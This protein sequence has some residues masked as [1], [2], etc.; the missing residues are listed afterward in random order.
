MAIDFS[1]VYSQNFDSLAISGA[2]LAWSNNV[3]L[4]GW[5][6]FNKNLS[7]IATY[8]A[9]DGNTNVGNFYS[10]GVSGAAER[11]LGGIASGNVYFG[12][13]VPLANDVAGWV[14]VAAKNVTGSTLD[15]LTLSFD[16]EQWR[17][18]GNMTAQSMVLQYG[19]GASFSTVSSWTT[20]GGNFDWTSPVA[21]TP[22]AP[23]N[24]NVEG[25]VAN[26]G[27]TLTGLNWVSNETLWIRWVELNNAGSDHGLA[28]DNFRMAIPEVIITESGS[29]TQVTE[30]GA[31]DSYTVVLRTPPSTGTLVTVALN[32]G[33]QVTVDQPTLVFTDLTWNV[34]KTVTVMA[35]DDAAIEGNHTGMIAHTVTSGDAAYNGLSVAPLTVSITDNDS[36]P[37]VAPVPKPVP[38]PAEELRPAIA[39]TDATGG[40]IADGTPDFLTFRAIA[41]ESAE[42]LLTIRNTGNGPLRL[43]DLTLPDGFSLGTTLPSSLAPGETVRLPLRLTATAPGTVSGIFGLRTND[44]AIDLFN[45]PLL[46]TV[47]AMIAPSPCEALMPTAPDLDFVTP[48]R[49]PNLTLKG[50]DGDDTLRG[51]DGDDFLSGGGG[52]DQI[53]GG[54]GDDLI[55]G[56][57][58]TLIPGD[59]D[60]DELYGGE[61]RDRI[62]GGGGNDL[63]HSGQGDD[64]VHGGQGE[65]EL[66][67]DRGDDW[68]SGDDGNDTL[69]GGTNDPNTP[70]LTGRDTLLG[71][72][73]DDWLFGNQGDDVLVGGDGNDT[74]H[75]GQDDDILIG[76]DG[77]DWLFGDAGND[78]LCGGAGADYFAV[79][80]DRGGTVTILDF[81]G[82]RDRLVLPTGLSFEALSLTVSDGFLN[83]RNGP[84]LIAKIANLTPNQLTTAD[85]VASPV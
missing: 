34:P 35:V 79:R 56:A 72:S 55:L 20:P 29:S 28:I 73:G 38:K 32:S 9:T 21:T 15:R 1:G 25:R 14:A 58:A 24:G 41:G 69:Y 46:G 5:F 81:E 61:G 47:E 17:N 37:G 84:D 59:L 3:I 80:G 64:F 16:G 63:I 12:S 67:G 39:V 65:D 78:T 43:F 13:P 82:G 2:G 45:F 8:G 62:G 66:W 49:S 52:N 85:V 42:Q 76:G 7:D 4:P 51:S 75:G 27:G 10:F 6:L 57:P 50:G 44:P 54:L 68:L 33:S 60:R 74:L 36:P 23:V 26:R 40:P 22:A 11:A 83:L 53:F 31:T 18:G 71:G 48:L 77:D 70:D 19:L 30:G